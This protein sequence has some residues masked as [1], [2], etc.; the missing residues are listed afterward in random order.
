MAINID[1]PGTSDD[2]ALLSVKVP[3]MMVTWEKSDDPMFADC[4]GGH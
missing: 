1:V 3:S 2:T 4:A